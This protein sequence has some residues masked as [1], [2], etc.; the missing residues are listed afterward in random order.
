MTRTGSLALSG[1]VNW[2]VGAFEGLTADDFVSVDELGTNGGLPSGTVSFQSGETSKDIYITLK[3]DTIVENNEAVNVTI[4]TGIVGGDII[5]STAEGNI[6]ED[7]SNW[8]VQ[9]VTP[10]SQNEGDASGSVSYTFTIVRSGSTFGAATVDWELSGI[11][12]N[13]ADA[14]DFG[15]Q[16][17]PSGTVA[18]ADGESSKTVTV[19]IEGESAL[20][21]DEGFRITIS[22]PEGSGNDVLTTAT[23]DAVIANDDDVLSIE[24]ADADHAENSGGV[25]EYTFTLT[26]AGSSEGESTVQWR[27][28]GDVDASDFV[29]GSGTI[30]FA[31]GETEK[32][33]TLQAVGDTDVESSEGFTVELFNP[34]AGSVVD[35]AKASASGTIQN[36]DTDLNLSAVTSSA[37][38][39]DGAGGS[40]LYKIVRTGDL[41][42]ET[43][44]NWTVSGDV[45]AADFAEGVSGTLTFEAGQTEAFI[46]LTAV[47]DE[48]VEADEN[49]IVS[50]STPTSGAEVE[51]DG[52]AGVLINDDDTLSITAVDASKLE[53]DSGLVEYVFRVDRT[54][55]SVGTSTVD[56][57]LEGTGLHPAS[58][59]DF[60]AVSG[61]LTFAS[62]EESKLL[63]IQVKGDSEGEYN[64]DFAVT[65]SNPG[66]GSSIATATA[67][68][69][70]RNDEATLFI[71]T[72]DA[73]LTE[74]AEGE[75]TVFTFTVVREGDTS[76]VTS[77]MWSVVPAGDH[78]V[79]ALDFGGALPSGILVFNA[80]ESS[81]DITVVVE[82]DNVGEFNEAFKVVLSDTVGGTALEAEAEGSIL[83]DDTALFVSATDAVKEEGFE[84]QK[85]VMTFTVTRMGD[86]A[87][88]ASVDWK[89]AGQGT[90]WPDVSD[91]D[92]GQDALG[93]NGLPSGTVFFADNETS[94]T[95]TIT[96]LGDNIAGGDEGFTVNLENPTNATISQAS[97]SAVI[98][99]DD[100]VFGV[101]AVDAVH[102]E[103]AD[104]DVVDYTFKIVRS[105]NLSESAEVDWTVTGIGGDPVDADDFAGGGLPSG[106]VSFAAGETEKLITVQLK[107]DY[108]FESTEQFQVAVS[109][110]SNNASIDLGKASAVGEVKNDDGLFL[111]DALTPEL[112][113]GTDGEV[114]V[115]KFHIN[116]VGGTE[117]E[118]TIQWD[119]S[120]FG[121]HAADVTDF[122]D[123]AQLSGLETFAVGET[124]KTIS[125]AVKGDN[126]IEHAE[127]FQITLS[128]PGG[129]NSVNDWL[130]SAQARIE[131]DEHATIAIAASGAPEAV[132]GD[133]GT[134][135]FTYLITRDDASGPETTV[136]WS[137]E[138]NGDN[139][140]DLSDF[141]GDTSGSVTF[142]EGETSKEITVHVNGDTQ[143]EQNESF[144]VKIEV[145][146][147]SLG[148]A[149]VDAAQSSVLSVVQT[150]DVATDGV[151]VLSGTPSD[152][153]I[154]GQGGDDQLTGGGGNDAFHYTSPTDGMDTITDFSAGDTLSFDASAFGNLG[155]GGQLTV[156]RQEFVTD[157]ETTL[158][159]L[160]A[161]ADADVYLVDFDATFTLGVGE[162]GHMDELETALTDGDHT[163]AAVIAVS[164]DDGDTHV[165]YDA[166]TDAGTD[167]SGVVEVAQLDNVA[168][169]PSMTDDA[170]AMA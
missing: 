153:V 84:G 116:R 67:S 136:L 104:N 105:E 83:N 51:A 101:E 144:Q 152:D 150:D 45:D 80:G 43:V 36:D 19:T 90:F 155:D 160:A 48:G 3:G 117:A 91:F 166:D 27:I 8:T 76:G 71:S 68:G 70:I 79:Q 161:Q 55:S 24:A 64:E 140:T 141:S 170:V 94:K 86:T 111:V 157:V 14:A 34:G 25:S 87:G 26:R 139:P 75:K 145:D 29:T 129:S 118:S 125:I 54:G 147:D 62:G 99:D 109:T 46:S 103:G 156:V 61:S 81:K 114:T 132:E 123:A 21:A 60:E 82:G 15:S 112:S 122:V 131:A 17:F 92:S 65:L 154:T 30:T 121:E 158:N 142:A 102:Y 5:T 164:N 107:G 119:V 37:T 18:F 40:F 85:T 120:G 10:L 115:F 162:D 50:L 11:G 59:D 89:V 113:E 7:D 66:T 130:D 74:G 167:G 127:T 42:G 20:E 100:T 63:R 6:V 69:V 108:Q 49:F 163:G 12:D 31:N 88:A 52:I 16:W 148:I 78:P 93:N 41:G 165:Y 138:G 124:E 106:T 72:N 159:Q 96:I 23:V 110:S 126:I 2:T 56:W 33:L 137:V 57:N 146:P 77:T 9:S 13:P 22:N 47:G 44:V 134:T 32:T 35:V 38:E 135:D 58:V 1:D 95:I 128:N 169:A 73:Q 4:T 151:D 143:V 28:S 133:S 97:A 53:S 149:E 39:G 98:Q 168:E